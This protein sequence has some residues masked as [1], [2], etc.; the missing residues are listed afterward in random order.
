MKLKLVILYLM[1]AVATGAFAQPKKVNHKDAPK[2]TDIWV[3]FK[4]HFDLGFTDLPENVFARYR[5]EMMD[6]ALNV[7]EKNATLPQ[8]K[9]FAWT[10]PGWPLY[11]QILGPLQTPER[12]ARIEKAIRD[13]SI[14][15][16][17]LPFTMHTESLDYEDLVRGLGYSSNIARKYGLPLAISAKMTDVPSHSWILPTLLNNAG[18]KFLQ[19]GCNPASQYPRFPALFWWEGADGSKILCNYTPLYGSDIKPIK[20]WPSKNYLA[21]QM[22]GDNHGPPNEKEI[23]KLLAYAKK[24][25]PGIKIHFGTLDDFAKAVL[26]EKP[27]LPTVKG[28]CPDTWIHGLLS[29]PQETKLARNIRPL[30]SALDG[31]NTQM[32]IWG[33]PAG[34]V[35]AKLAKAYEQS[36]L[37]AEHTWGMNAEYGPRFS[38]G[39]DW[40]KWMAEAEAEPVPENGDYSKLKNSDAEN[41]KEGS[42]RK[43]LHSYDVKRQY[44]RNTN[45]IVSNELNTHLDLLAKSVNVAGKRLVV[46][47]PLP[48]KRSGIV[49]NPWEK[50]KTF[51]VKEIAP[52]GYVTYSQND[53]KELAVT[54]D[55]QPVFSTPNFKIVFD[56]SRGGISSLTEKTTGRELVDKSSK[57]VI[58]QFLHERFSTNEVDRWWNVYSRIKEGWGLNDLGKPG[59]I[60]AEKAPYVAFTP[61]DWKISVSHS[62]IADIATLTSLATQGFAKKYTLTFTFPRNDAHV[63]VEWAV[64]S[65]TADKQPEGGWLCF[66]FL[67]KNPNFTVGRLG[68]PINPVTDIVSGTNRYLMAVNSGVSITQADK[69]GAGLTPM[70]SPLISLGEPGLWEFALEH[71]PTIPSVFVNLYNNMWNTNFALWQDGSWSERVRIWPIDKNTPTAPNLIQ[72]S[73]EA[74]VPLLTGTAEG[75]AGKLAAKNTGISI[76]RTGV[77]VTAF[78][79]NPDGKGTVLRLWEQGGI[80][81]NITVTLPKGSTYTKMI[82]VNLRGEVAGKPIYVSKDKVTFFIHAYAPASFILTISSI[83]HRAAAL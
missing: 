68:G 13:G 40:K 73:W 27:N 62:E 81:G 28:D 77:L 65:K 46:Y 64:E 63:D 67:V 51:Y 31:L 25:L 7:I 56:L 54:N 8:E 45:D 18:I 75:A 4:T 37:Y 39:D 6:N 36:L 19:L 71:T 53:L 59:M 32:G 12:K 49:A 82:P 23:A 1:M 20:D 24:E 61:N 44:I 70:D 41:T 3:V 55:E 52:S 14:V 33:T 11:A 38:Y 69:S 78:G 60:N 58:G 34:S 42:K 50:E 35:S 22:T 15:A 9:R 21:M 16:H 74:R 10:V 79:E 17:G 47:N 48:W 72:K 76:S 5:G 57:Y 26:A 30:E 2:V 29:N 80:S 66:P 83:E 43:W